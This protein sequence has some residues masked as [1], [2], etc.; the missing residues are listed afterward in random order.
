M[1]ELQSAIETPQKAEGDAG[2]FY[3]SGGILPGPPRM[4][5]NC[6]G[7]APEAVWDGSQTNFLCHDCGTCWHVGMGCVWAVH[8]PAA[9]AARAAQLATPSRP[10]E[11][12]R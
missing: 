6:G 9:S 1:T 5:P 4:C 10:G 7:P 12:D 11:P 3:A 8:P 2:G